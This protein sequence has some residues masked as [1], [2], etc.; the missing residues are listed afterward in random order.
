MTAMLDVFWGETSEE[1]PD[2]A[3]LFGANDDD[4]AHLL[5]N[6]RAAF[7][8][9]DLTGDEALR[10]AKLAEAAAWAIRRRRDADALDRMQAELDAK[11]A[12]VRRLNATLLQSRRTLQGAL[13]AARAG[14]WE[15][16]LSDERLT[17]TNVVYHLFEAPPGATLHRNDVLG[18]YAPSSLRALEEVRGAAIRTGGRFGL[19][20]EITTLKGRRRWIRLSGVAER[21]G[22][23]VR[24]YGMKQD[25]TEERDIADH[26]RRLSEADALTGL[27]NR[28]LFEEKLAELAVDP[29]SAL[30]LVD[31][32]R[33]KQ[34]NDTLGHVAG[35]SYLKQVAARLRRVCRGAAL[36]ARIGGDEFAALFTGDHNRTDVERCAQEVVEALRIPVERGDFLVELGASVGVARA[37]GRS[38]SDWFVQADVALYAAKA[39]GRG[40]FRTFAG[41]SDMRRKA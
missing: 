37:E 9:A 19:D 26:A 7:A 31:L 18:C 34:L 12:L 21:R 6:I 14:L 40:T 25:V 15:C 22:A 33:F 10:L 23:S 29:Q 28:R 39:A 11:A 20:A 38:P 27:A 32:D 2:V 17:W 30:L 24:L 4:E 16:R 13:S 41:A 8:N 36:V 35:D 5:A 3:G 1:L